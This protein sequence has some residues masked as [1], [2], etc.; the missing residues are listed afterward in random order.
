[1]KTS[2]ALNTLSAIYLLGASAFGIAIAL[3]RNPDWAAAAQHAAEVSWPVIQRGAAI[4]ND[5]AVQPALRKLAEAD[6]AFFDAIDPQPVAVATVKPAPTV[7]KK[8]VTVVVARQVPHQVQK[9]I[10]SP[11]L[12]PAIAE[13]QPTPQIAKVETSKPAMTLAP[14]Q[15]PAKVARRTRLVPIFLRRA[16]QNSRA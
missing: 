13:T 16:P 7:A 10:V 2:R 15:A 8:A 4:A 12:R 11:P 14:E 3:Q 1:M 5:S 6:K 9:T